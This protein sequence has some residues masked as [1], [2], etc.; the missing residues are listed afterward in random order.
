MSKEPDCL[1]PEEIHALVRSL[2]RIRK[3]NNESNRYGQSSPVAFQVIQAE[4]NRWIK[5][6]DFVVNKRRA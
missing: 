1:F 5:L 3:Y 2:K 6:L 4:S